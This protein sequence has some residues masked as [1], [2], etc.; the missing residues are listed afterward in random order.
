MMDIVNGLFRYFDFWVLCAC[1]SLS[2]DDGF[3]AI[4][5]ILLQ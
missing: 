1:P 4:E 2:C 3:V 5:Q